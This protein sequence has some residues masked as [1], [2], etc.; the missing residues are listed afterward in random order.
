M[1]A[2]MC[3]VYQLDHRLESYHL[4]SQHVCVCVVTY[5]LV[6]E[7]YISMFTRPQIWHTTSC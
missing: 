7:Q 5:Y 1:C 4:E 2:Y 3:V 6:M